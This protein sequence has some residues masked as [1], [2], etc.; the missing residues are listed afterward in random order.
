MA[1][2]FVDNRDESTDVDEDESDCVDQRPCGLKCITSVAQK[3]R[4]CPD[5]LVQQPEAI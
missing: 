4:D 2:S 1:S 3:F 5:Y